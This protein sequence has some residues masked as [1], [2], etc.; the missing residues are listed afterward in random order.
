[1]DE[2]ANQ[3]YTLDGGATFNL[4]DPMLID[5][6]LLNN[7]LATFSKPVTGS[8]TELV[9]T[10]TAQGDGG[11]EAVAFENLVILSVPP[12]VDV[13]AFDM[14]GSASQKLNSFTKFAPPFSSA[15]VAFVL[16]P[17]SGK[18]WTPVSPT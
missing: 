7:N 12:A 14:V 3:D 17:P 18:K 13:V 9:I 1:M 11:S 5:G 2:A 10:V 4:N 15:Q 8:G 6:V 16:I